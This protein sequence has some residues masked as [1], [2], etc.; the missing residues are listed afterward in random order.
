[1]ADEIPLS[2]SVNLSCSEV[3]G[4]NDKKVEIEVGLSSLSVSPK[5][6]KKLLVLDLNGLLIHGTHRANKFDIPL[7]RRPD[8]VY[9]QRLGSTHCYD[10]I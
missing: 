2:L 4:D 6:E 10:Q 3:D 5:K 8:A 9:G 1:M 7:N